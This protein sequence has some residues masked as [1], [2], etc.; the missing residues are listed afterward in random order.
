M[1]PS[2]HYLRLRVW[3]NDQMLYYVPKPEEDISDLVRTG[4]LKVMSPNTCFSCLFFF[5]LLLLF[6]VRSLS[7]TNDASLEKKGSPPNN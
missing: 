1:D 7:G 5:L 2:S 6:L 3:T 4:A